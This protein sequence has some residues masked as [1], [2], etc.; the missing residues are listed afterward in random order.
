MARVYNIT[1]KLDFQDNPVLKIKD[2]E[3]EVN[4]DAK[5]ILKVMSII[6]DGENI[7]PDDIL[8]VFEIIFSKTEQ[9]KVEKLNLQFSDFQTVVL[10][11]INIAAG[12]DDGE[13]E[14]N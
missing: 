4:T 13:P 7:T 1:D 12:N 14:K 9:K 6:G 2:V 3:V 11:A 8:A 10:T 5:S